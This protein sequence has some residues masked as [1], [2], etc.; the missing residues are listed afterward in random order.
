MRTELR[1]EGGE[2]VSWGLEEA[3]NSTHGISVI[4]GTVLVLKELWAAPWR[5][6]NFYS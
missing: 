1:G 2:G 5:T 4:Y 3:G 6:R